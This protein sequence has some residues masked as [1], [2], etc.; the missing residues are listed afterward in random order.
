[1]CW[2]TV[3]LT[4][5]AAL[6][7]AT[8]GPGHAGN[9]IGPPT[10]G[11]EI[12]R[13]PDGSSAPSLTAPSVVDTLVLS[14][15]TV[16]TGNFAAALG[17]SPVAVA[18]DPVQSQIFVVDAGVE[19]GD[20]ASGVSVISDHTGEV[21]DFFAA[22]TL[23]AAIAFDPVQDQVFVAN[24]GS[25]NV[26]VINASTEEVVATLPVG[27]S[28]R[29]LAYDPADGD[30]YVANYGSGNLTILN[31]AMDSVTPT[32]VSVGSH[33]D[34][35]AFAAATDELFVANQGADP[36]LVP[37]TVSIVNASNGSVA[38]TVTV[39]F[40]PT[41]MAW[42]PTED[43]LYVTDA[44]SSNVSVLSGSNS[45]D[46][47]ASPVGTQPVALAIDPAADAVLV[48]NAG[49]GNITVLDDRTNASI[50]NIT[51]P[52]PPSGLVY[53]AGRGLVYD[54]GANS[55]MLYAINATTFA[56]GTTSLIS[57]WPWGLA[58][59]S[60][61]HTLYVGDYSGSELD[62]VSTYLLTV[63]ATLSL[64]FEPAGLVY[65]SARDQ[66]FAGSSG[67][68]GPSEVSVVNSSTDEVAKSVVTGVYPIAS[69]YDPA[70][71]T[72]YTANY[73]QDNVSGI[74]DSDDHVG[75]GIPLTGEL[76]PAAL[77]FDPALGEL[78]VADRGTGA[79]TAISDTTNMTRVNFPVGSA[80]DALAYDPANDEVF[81]ANYGSNSV[82]VLSAENNSVVTTVPVGYR[83]SALAFDNLNDEVYVANLGSANLSVISAS[84]DQVLTSV[85]VGPAPGDI[86][87]DQWTDRLYVANLW[88][89]TISVV[90]PGGVDRN[91]VEFT[92]NGL[93]SGT[94]WS[95]TLNGTIESDA[96]H[97]ISFVEPFGNYTYT[98]Q[99]A[100]TST[101]VYS[102]TPPMGTVNMTTGNSVSVVI[103]FSAAAFAVEFAES[104][105]P[106]GSEWNVTL[107]NDTAYF[108]TPTYTFFDPNGSY[109][110][111]VGNASG[112]DPSPA[113]G[114]VNVSGS[115]DQIDVQYGL[116]LTPTYSV[117]FLESGVTSGNEWWVN[118][119]N[120]QSFPSTLPYVSFSEPNGTYSY[121][122]T[123]TGVRNSSGT[124]TID[125]AP[126][127]PVEISFGSP[128]G[129]TS[130]SGISPMESELLG[131]AVIVV[132][133]VA[134]AA[135]ILWIGRARRRPAAPAYI[136]GRP[137]PETRA[138]DEDD[139]SED[140]EDEEL[141]FGTPDARFDDDETLN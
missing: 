73:L 6:G 80:P 26:T 63:N 62:T 131:I 91:V 3:A 41:A 103:N 34:A 30:V 42:D 28:P 5:A 59:D 94:P 102:P 88:G 44:N 122:A 139:G 46:V 11:G 70:V 17:Q 72:V 93:P 53:D 32:N 74:T 31:A 43:E 133:V 115:P 84:T 61:G 50:V 87:Y 116:N 58:L 65:D 13:S 111:W 89:G 64:P 75:V 106:L 79:V 12:A 45:T 77:A 85:P 100:N 35:V 48:G 129:S 128:P 4:L 140:D 118:L 105:L 136:G 2:V 127:A 38:R 81:V 47:S 69:A 55:S 22:G 90:N 52:S 33:P 86:V 57:S 36:G 24:E 97:S 67:P 56:P 95:V 134:V 125:G 92:E 123:A 82:T 117:T 101:E 40:G 54:V 138:D 108:S 15:G 119:S 130:P 121:T 104:G 16:H 8:A 49:S 135:A 14:D 124:F 132:V 37:G 10:L 27:S 126:P 113:N 39:G 141:E 98:V 114:T 96:P 20:N 120:N 60:S 51:L 83:P 71:G 1:M 66:V 76:N 21:V 137:A 68:P 9:G 19:P 18:Y 25:G 112:Y 107:G 23:P 29:S 110:Y 7:S 78:F 99:G 109:D